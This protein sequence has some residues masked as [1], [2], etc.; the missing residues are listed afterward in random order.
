MQRTSSSKNFA[1][2]C[3]SWEIEWQQF[4]DFELRSR[5]HG[6]FQKSRLLQVYHRSPNALC[7]LSPVLFDLDTAPNRRLQIQI[8]SRLCWISADAHSTPPHS[9][10]PCY[11][12]T[13]AT[14]YSADSDPVYFV[15]INRFRSSYSAKTTCSRI[16]SMAFCTGV[17]NPVTEQ[18]WNSV[19]VYVYTCHGNSL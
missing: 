3:C 11:K 16:E 12:H 2:S 19:Q 14:W 1:I 15:S 13:H 18:V 5:N 6:N 7:L 17:I 9:L 10:G 8:Q 4:P